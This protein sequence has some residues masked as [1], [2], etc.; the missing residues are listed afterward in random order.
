MIILALA[1]STLA[2]LAWSAHGSA[3]PGHRH[4]VVATHNMP[5]IWML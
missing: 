4:A 1:F 3:H 5:R 2:L